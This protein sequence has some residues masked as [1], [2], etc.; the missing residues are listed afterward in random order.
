MK[1][2]NKHMYKHTVKLSLPLQKETLVPSYVSPSYSPERP[3]YE[4][5]EFLNGSKISKGCILNE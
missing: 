5:N 1:V 2:N 4:T 3:E